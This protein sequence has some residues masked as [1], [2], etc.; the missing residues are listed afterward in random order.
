VAA[1]LGTFA[2]VAAGWSTVS[3]IGVK[4]LTLALVASPVTGGFAYWQVKEHH[5]R[6]LLS[7]DNVLTTADAAAFAQR[8][9]KLVSVERSL[10]QL[11]PDI[12]DFTG[13]EDESAHVQDLLEASATATTV[14]I[15]AGQGGIGKTTLAIHEAHQLRHLFPDGQLYVNLRGAADQRLD[16]V[17]VLG[18]ALIVL[19][20]ERSALPYGR[21]ERARLYRA[22][23]DTKKILVVLDN[24]FDEEQVRPLIPGSPSSAVLITSRSRLDGLAGSHVVELDVL[25]LPEA[26]RQTRIRVWAAMVAAARG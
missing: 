14:T 6:A 10:F 5:S 12:G 22:R 23:L 21:E 3:N 25:E 13:R 24:A 7:K 26:V 19:G 9:T 2:A 15:I 18:E 1:A 16:P 17:A 8:Q 4:Q 11:P 20:L